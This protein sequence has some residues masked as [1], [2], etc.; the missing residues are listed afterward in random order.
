MLRKQYKAMPSDIKTQ[1]EAL[2][3]A[4][5]E[6]PRPGEAL[7]GV[8]PLKDGQSNDEFTAPFDDGLLVYRIMPWVDY[9]VLRLALVVWLEH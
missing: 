5:S 7:L 4:L 2:V 6:H 9:R 1:F 3:R 8:L